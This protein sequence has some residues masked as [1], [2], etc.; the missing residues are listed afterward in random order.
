MVK[1]SLSSGTFLAK[2]ACKGM[3]EGGGKRRRDGE[4]GGKGEGMGKEEEER[5]GEEKE[6]RRGGIL[7]SLRRLVVI[8]KRNRNWML[9]VIISKIM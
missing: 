8:A 3:R 5:K 4:G 1:D 7:G 2:D 6:R 9:R